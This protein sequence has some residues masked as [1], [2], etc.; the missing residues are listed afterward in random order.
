MSDLSSIVIW[1][2]TI[3]I[4]GIIFLPITSFLFRKFIDRG[5]IFTKVIGIVF[6]SYLIW[7]LGSF[8]IL[9]FTRLT[10]MIILLGCT[11]IGL[12]ISKAGK[13]GNHISKP[14]WGWI[15]FEESLF[16][17][18]LSFWAYVRATE[19]SIRGLEKFMDFGFVN[20]I[21]R[22]TFFPPLDMWLTKSP[23]YSG[24]YFI[25]YYYFGH[26]IAAFLTKLSGIDSAVTYNLMLATLFAF[27]FTLPFSIGANLY[28]LFKSNNDPR[29]TFR[30]NDPGSLRLEGRVSLKIV[31]VG[32]LAAFLVAAAGN[33][34]TLYVFTSGYPNENPEPPWK[35]SF[36]FYPERY[37][38]PNA[39]RFIPFTIHEFPIYSFVVADLHG[40]VSDIPI[41]LFT[42]AFLLAL[43]IEEKSNRS[44]EKQEQNNFRTSDRGINNF[45][46]EFEKHTS[47]SPAKIALLGMLL[48]VMYMT[49]AWDGII[50]MMLSCLVIFYRNLAARRYEPEVTLFASFYRTFSA[51]LFLVFFFL[52]F[53][54]PFFASFKPFVSGI[55]VLCPPAFLAGKNIGPFLFE[56]GKCQK[57]PLYQFIILWGFFYFNVIGYLVFVLFP[58]IRS[59]SQ[60]PSSKSQKTSD[61]QT[62][63]K[64]QALNFKERLTFKHKIINFL[65]FR[66]LNLF[67]NLKLKIEN[68]S[69]ADIFVLLMILISTFLLAFP[70][71]FYIKDIYPAHYRANTMFKLGYQ[72]FMM[73]GISSAY[74]LFRIKH[75]GIRSLKSSIFYFLFSLFFFLVAIYPYFAIN[76]YYGGLQVYRGLNGLNWLASQFPDDYQAILWLRKNIQCDSGFM[77]QCNNQ[78]VIAE[79]NGDSYT[80][81]ARVSA[82]TGLPT[83]V[84]WPVHEWLWRGSYD[85]AGKRIPEVATIYESKDMEQTMEIL[86]KYKVEYIFLGA[87]EK[88]KYKNLNEEKLQNLGKIVFE[89][90]G[91]KIYKLN[92]F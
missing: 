79:A 37:W 78:P 46:Q 86:R 54:L 71:F 49:N 52:L 32:L 39:T 13:N 28:Y 56:A 88:E 21:L 91:T 24:G 8:G 6:S 26:Y 76:S 18:C 82:N 51:S 58:S 31:L 5:Y 47:I 9:P 38:Y 1:W 69:P 42:I 2:L 80:D 17:I 55:G 29:S 19:P 90:G 70:E 53:G 40:H 4:V 15:I 68:F 85:E 87:L 92:P 64:F 77:Q 61:V 89:S 30:R 33:L 59:K 3:F 16:F 60:I 44:P 10:I 57:S 22:S 50:Y 62:N 66:I 81:Y 72:A 20:S 25:N 7:I 36:G 23:D 45:W 65:K 73:L 48:A 74:I 27:T 14:G 34:H 43:I 12:W 67:E 41:V 35:L 11:L 75:L 83:I 84:G 63:P